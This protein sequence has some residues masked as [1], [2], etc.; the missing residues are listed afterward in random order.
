MNKQALEKVFT[1][2]AMSLLTAAVSFLWDLS[3]SIG[4]LNKQVAVVIEQVG[5]NEKHFQS[6]V[7]GQEKRLESLEDQLRVLNNRIAY[8]TNFVNDEKLKE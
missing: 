4:E 8:I 7:L 5:S 1:W 6:Q 3:K 2:L